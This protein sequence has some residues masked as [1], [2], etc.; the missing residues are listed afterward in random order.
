VVAPLGV[1]TFRPLNGQIVVGWTRPLSYTGMML[2]ISSEEG[3]MGDGSRLPPTGMFTATNQAN[4]QTVFMRLAGMNGD[5]LGPPSQPQAVTPKADPDPPNGWLLINNGAPVTQGRHAVL[6]I[7][8]SDTPADGVIQG[9]NAHM[10]DEVSKSINEVTGD[11]QMK[12]S[13]DGSMAGAQWEP[14]AATK[15][16]TLDCDD[17][18]VCTVFAQF[19][20][21]ADNESL[22]VSDQILL[23]MLDLFLPL[24]A[25][26]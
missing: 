14:L 21:G 15:D 19:K 24:I 8:S 12:I 10:T 7:S 6:Y 25:K 17:G 18:E 2:Y 20:D 5:G 23:E 9:A 13:N 4:D 1:V 26:H 16:W 11:V 22:I 3:E